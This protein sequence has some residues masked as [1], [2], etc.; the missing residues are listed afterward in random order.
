MIIKLYLKH[1][2]GVY[3]VSK[4]PNEKKLG[5]RSGLISSRE[6]MEDICVDPTQKQKNSRLPICNTQAINSGGTKNIAGNHNLAPN[7]L[8]FK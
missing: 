2:A 1:L 6:L 4:S 7:L 8:N 3:L 5:I